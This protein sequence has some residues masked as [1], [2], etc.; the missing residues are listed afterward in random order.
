MHFL[1]ILIQKINSACNSAPLR[2]NLDT[3]YS[4][5][6]SYFSMDSVTGVLTVKNHLADL[7]GMECAPI[8][9]KFNAQEGESLD[10]V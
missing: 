8:V 10:Q 3:S 1:N 2:Y 4:K 7:D 9:L 5:Q 6:A